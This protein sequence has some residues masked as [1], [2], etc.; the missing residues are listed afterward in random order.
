MRRTAKGSNPFEEQ[1][2]E[3]EVMRT[4]TTSLLKEAKQVRESYQEEVPTGDMAGFGDL[5]EKIKEQEKT[6]NF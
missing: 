3:E 1:K 4:S 2:Q 5:I 6:I